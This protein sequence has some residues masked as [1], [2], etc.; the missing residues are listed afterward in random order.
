MAGEAVF[1]K[2]KVIIKLGNIAVHS[3]RDIPQTDSQQA[4]KEL[5]HFCYWFARLYARGKKP[6]AL[7]VFDL[8]ALPTTT[9]AKQTLDQLKRLETQL[10]EKD[11][12][13]SI[14]LADK[15][16]LDAEIKRLR[17]EVAEAK[18][19]AAQLSAEDRQ[20][21]ADQISGVPTQME[22]ESEEAKR[23]DLLML[24]LQLA[25][26]GKE[27]SFERL[28]EQVRMIA[29]LLEEKQTIP[30]VGKQLDHIQ[31]VQ[32]D[33]WW[34]DV[35]IPML[36]KIR[37]RLRDLVQF[38][39][40]RERKPIYT[41]FED[42]MGQDSPMDL[43]EFVGQDTFERFRD[44]ARAFLR[45]HMDIEAV[46]KLHTNEPLSSG[47]VDDLERILADNKIDKQ[48]YIDQAKQDNETFGVFVRTLIGLDREVAKGLFNE[49]LAST[50][51]NAN[52]I[53]FINLIINQLVDH[54]IVD[55]G[56]LYESPF[57]DISPT[58]PDALFTAEQVNRIIQLLEKI[59]T[60]ALAA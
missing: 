5:F 15:E 19:T 60:A 31:E 53:E 29:G 41:N 52:Q 27:P 14:V 7:L 49:F 35:T 46:R 21:L 57:T 17:K 4:V 23:F 44:K 50:T 3:H 34:Q 28:R 9:V 43:S 11:E 48:E 26:L 59:K 20:I 58:G 8:A 25:M 51:Y 36:E 56:L 38:I 6:D 2:A 40:K 32:K 33:E 13:L 18:Q 54:G 12:M 16:N 24:K 47:D 30:M 22:R 45:K 39:E 42:E 37:R 1:N 10:V 55:V